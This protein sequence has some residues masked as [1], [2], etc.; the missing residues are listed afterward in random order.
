[1]IL[2]PVGKN[3]SGKRP[4]TKEDW[5]Q[6]IHSGVD[7]ILSLEWGWFEWWHHR[8]NQLNIEGV[9]RGL[10]VMN[11]R[12][13]DFRVPTPDETTAAQRVLRDPRFKCVYFCCLHGQDRTGW[14][15]AVERKVERWT[16]PRAI[17]EW[18]ELGFHRWFYGGWIPEFEKRYP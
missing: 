10:V 18:L 15:R 6:L 7:A 13:S 12:W 2:T 8:I 17:S 9:T 5:D 1:M 3:L 4:E 16:T 11:H 14:L